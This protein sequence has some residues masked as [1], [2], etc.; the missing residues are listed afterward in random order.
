MQPGNG[1]E[2]LGCRASAELGW[3]GQEPS[4]DEAK[5]RVQLKDEGRGLV[6]LWELVT[7]VQ[8]WALGEPQH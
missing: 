5:C 8:H 1:V 3:D 4:A 7:H 6:G 2:V